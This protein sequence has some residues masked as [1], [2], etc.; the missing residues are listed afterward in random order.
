M[1]D[2]DHTS[3]EESLN[4]IFTEF[5]RTF[6]NFNDASSYSCKKYSI[7]QCA[8]ETILEIQFGANGNVLEII[9]EGDVITSCKYFRKGFFRSKILWKFENFDPINP[10][11][12]ISG[13][14]LLIR[15]ELSTYLRDE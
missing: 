5:R 10:V 1:K 6:Q 8:Y 4:E 9:M 2:E 11:P 14:F 13:K 15:E 7:T 3:K 12:T